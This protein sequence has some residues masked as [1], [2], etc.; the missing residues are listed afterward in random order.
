MIRA[1]ASIAML[2]ALV[3]AGCGNAPSAVAAEDDCPTCTAELRSWVVFGRGRHLLLRIDCPEP[4]EHLDGVVEFTNVSLRRD[5]VAPVEAVTQGADVP[6]GEWAE[7]LA[8]TGPARL[9]R[10]SRGGQLKPALGSGAERLEAVYEIDCAQAEALQR[11]RV[12]DVTYELLGPNSNSGLATAMREVGLELPEHV[13]RGGG[14]LGAFPGVTLD[15]G[16]D[17]RTA[18]WA[19]AGLPAGPTEPGTRREVR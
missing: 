3:L 15:P 8:R 12:W 9:G 5:F 19:R 11:D 1:F 18:E 4:I 13:S 6:G 16:E 2:C 14:A 7:V 10:M 17:L